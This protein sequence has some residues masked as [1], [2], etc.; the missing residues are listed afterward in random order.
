MTEQIETLRP[1]RR[2]RL[3]RW[4]RRIGIV[5]SVLLLTAAILDRLFPLPL[6]K[7]DGGS[8]VVL[9]RDGTPLR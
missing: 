4:L 8:T 6:P 9:A 5:F 7:P 3:W 2:R 1:G